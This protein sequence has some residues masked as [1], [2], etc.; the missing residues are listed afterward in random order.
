MATDIKNDANLSTNLVSAWLTDDSG[1]LTDLH[2]SNDLTNNNTVTEVAGVQGDAG[3]FESS[4]SQSLSITD[5]SQSGLDITGDISIACWLKFETVSGSLNVASKSNNTGSQVSWELKHE[6]ALN[7]GFVLSANGSAVEKYEYAYVPSTATWYHFAIS[8]NFTTKTA[9]FY[10][11]GSS[12]GT[13]AT[14]TASSMFNS[15]APFR[16]G[17]GRDATGFFDGVINQMLIWN[18]VISSTE[19]SDLYNSGSGIPYEAAGGGVNTARNLLILG[20]G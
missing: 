17:A 19:V 3:D 1:L 6:D 2:G 15:S 5:G 8:V 16:I 12:I 4:S 10:V 11:N 9:T 20:A 7:W 14:G 13:D 18:K